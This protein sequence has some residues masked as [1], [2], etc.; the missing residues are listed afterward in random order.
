MREADLYFEI[1]N[2]TNGEPVP[3]GE[4]GEVVFTTLTRV[5]CH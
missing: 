4:E 5:A 2:P 1:I 3:D